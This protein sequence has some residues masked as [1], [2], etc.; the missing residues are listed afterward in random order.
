ILALNTALFAAV[1]ELPGR[2]HLPVARLN[3]GAMLDYALTHACAGLAGHYS[4]LG[5]EH[6]AELQA[7]GQQVGTGFVDSR[8]ILWREINRGVDWIFSNRAADL[9]RL[10]D[11]ARASR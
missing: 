2:C 9:Q 5:Q 6:V 8:N 3:S 1:R 4:L 7:A 11:N 10:V